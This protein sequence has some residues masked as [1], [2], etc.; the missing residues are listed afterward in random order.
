MKMVLRK[1]F[2]TPNENLKTNPQKAK[3]HSKN[4]HV[5]TNE[6]RAMNIAE[7]KVSDKHSSNGKMRTFSQQLSKGSIHVSTDSIKNGVKKYQESLENSDDGVKV[8]GKS[9]TYTV[10]ASAKV[11]KAIKNHKVKLESSEKLKHT[12]E[13]IKVQKNKVKTHKQKL[14]KETDSDKLAHIQKTLKQDKGQLKKT[15]QEK[16]SLQK[17]VNGTSFRKKALLSPLTASKKG[18]SSYKKNLESSDDGVKVVGKSASFVKESIKN[19][20]RTKRKILKSGDKLK[21]HQGKLKVKNP[22]LLKAKKKAVPIKQ[23]QKKLQKKA[24]Q[25]RMIQQQKKKGIKVGSTKIG[26]A[27]K[28][29][30]GNFKKNFSVTAIKKFIGGKLAVAFGAL[31]IKLLPVLVIV[32]L[33]FTIAGVIMSLGGASEQYS[34]N[35]GIAQNLSPEVE[36]WRDLVTKEATE[37][38]MEDY[39]DL[40]LA[41]IQVESEG[42][43]YRDIM[44]SS[45]SAG[46]PRNTYQNETDSVRQGVKHLKNIVSILNSY[47]PSYAN[48]A[49]LLAQSY[50]FGSAFAHY[51]GKRGGTYTLEVAEAYSRDIV[52]PSL[53]NHTGLR[54]QYINPISISLGKTYLYRNG[55]NYMYGDMVGQYIQSYDGTQL[56]PPVSPLR[57]NSHFGNRPSP[58]GIGSTNHKGIDFACVDY[59]TPIKAVQSGEVVHSGNA[60]GLGTAVVIKHSDSFF[61][62]YGH[63]SVSNVKKG[64]KVTQGQ[65]VGVCGN[66]GTSTGSHLHLEISPIPFKNQVDP[67]PYFKHLLG[68]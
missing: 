21:T 34:A 14:S 24:I 29:M 56:A 9:S 65:Q 63:M 54:Y 43:R 30:F 16:K 46:L 28:R 15:K 8:V 32:L 7:D 35:I 45:E 64:D 25:R 39:I 61:T 5:S 49:K 52:A 41:I 2:D 53:G 59:I 50:N 23:Q 42:Y 47:D 66:T 51:V 13:Q 57:V 22:E 18:V 40:F 68:G 55:G 1:E 20:N 19:I 31:G 26:G 60:G 27:F 67:F 37:Q 48:N 10:K 4:K 17:K 11:M 58:G 6:E 36:K 62:T 38:G 44:Q 12:K 3:I 33:F